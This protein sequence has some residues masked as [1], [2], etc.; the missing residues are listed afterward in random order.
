[1]GV[2]ATAVTAVADSAAMAAAITIET[3]FGA[4]G[5]RQLSSISSQRPDTLPALFLMKPSKV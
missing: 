2:A 5:Y 3:S 4:D 1:M